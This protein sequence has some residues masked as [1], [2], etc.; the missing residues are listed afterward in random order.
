MEAEE[1]RTNKS[2][3]VETEI[4]NESVEGKAK[5]FGFQLLQ[6]NK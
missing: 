1:T 3:K 2:K 4:E 5:E 6:S